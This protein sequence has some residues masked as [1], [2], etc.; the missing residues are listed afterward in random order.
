MAKYQFLDPLSSEEF[1]ALETDIKQHGVKVPVE[2][3]DEG[4][5]LDG[6][7][8]VEIANRHKLDYPKIVRQFATELEKQEH[9]IKLNLLRRHLEPWRWGRA[10]KQLLEVRG[11]KR[12]KGGDRK[13]TATV[14]VDTVAETAGELGVSDRTARHRLALAD[15]FEAE[16]SAAEQ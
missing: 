16:L 15:V 3:D 10:F 6:H 5:I 11:V 9:S 14:A 12:G 4:N 7:Y 2:F 1:A 8:R 13:S